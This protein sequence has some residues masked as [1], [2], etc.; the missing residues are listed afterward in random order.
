M[1]IS[2]S[3]LHVM[4]NKQ[5]SHMQQ[6]VT[7]HAPLMNTKMK[8][9]QSAPDVVHTAMQTHYHLGKSLIM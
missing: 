8:T 7:V 9:L 5:Y 4:C 1:Y 6:I 3:N 2:C